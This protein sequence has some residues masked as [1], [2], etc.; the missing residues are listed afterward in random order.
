MPGRPKKKMKEIQPLEDAAADIY[1]KVE[2]LAPRWITKKHFGVRRGSEP[3]PPT[4][5]LE[6]AWV[7]A[8]D[9]TAEAGI[10]MEEL[11][12]LLREEAGITE[13]GPVEQTMADDDDSN[14]AD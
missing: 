14:C 4:N 2:S 8:V 11:G 1:D 9:A 3:E 10:A 13:P 5:D 12:D 6:A 7:R